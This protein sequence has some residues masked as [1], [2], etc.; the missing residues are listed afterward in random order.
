ME[1]ERKRL[2]QEREV[3]RRREEKRAKE[4]SESN[5]TDNDNEANQHTDDKLAKVNEKLESNFSKTE[6]GK[7]RGEDTGTRET[8]VETE[9]EEELK[10][11]A[12]NKII[13][14]SKDSVDESDIPNLAK[15]INETIQKEI[16]GLPSQ[17][18]KT[19]A[20]WPKT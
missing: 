7:L 3:D 6:S 1:Q 5:K 2:E 4:E 19:K 18:A 16:A 13:A 14:T 20:N 17:K 9:E 8:V 10:L 15:E 12:E 11:K